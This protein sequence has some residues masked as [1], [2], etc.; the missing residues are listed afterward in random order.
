MWPEALTALGAGAALSWMLVRLALGLAT[1][2][3]MLDIPGARQCH[4]EPTPG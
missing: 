1:G 3:G 2:A 4:V